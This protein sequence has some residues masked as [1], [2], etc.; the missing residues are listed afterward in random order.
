MYKSNHLKLE[1]QLK[2]AIPA[3]SI[4]NMICALIIFI[5]LI[6]GSTIID[7]QQYNNK[8][9]LGFYVYSKTNP[10]AQFTWYGLMLIIV[11]LISLISLFFVSIKY[12]TTYKLFLRK[13]A[14]L[15]TLTN[16]MLCS[17][18]F[19]FSLITMFYNI[20]P[21][22]HLSKTNVV[23]Y[24][25]FFSMN[26]V[27]SDILVS[28]LLPSAKIFISLFVILYI[29]NITSNGFANSSQAIRWNW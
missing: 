1:S 21:I 17:C 9:Y 10:H 22:L 13:Y 27:N 12:W 16:L 11:Y 18:L 23:I 6:I 8:L 7:F 26:L 5:L 2:I 28:Q 4:I 20:A 3:F 19:I 14:K 25:G 29:A 15:I 24:N